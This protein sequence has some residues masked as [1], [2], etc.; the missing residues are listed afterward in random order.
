MALVNVPQEDGEITVA[1][2]GD[3]PTTYPVTNGQVTVDEADLAV[4]L[5]SIEGSSL[6][7]GGS[8]A[9]DGSDNQGGS[10]ALS[11]ED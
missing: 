2:A 4:F 10:P 3:A 11:P 1:H 8:P 7:D 6:A 9:A 5:H